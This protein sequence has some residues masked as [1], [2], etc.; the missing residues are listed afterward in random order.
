M[1]PGCQWTVA[2]RVL[3][4]LGGE[5]HHAGQRRRLEEDSGDATPH[6]ARL[7][8]ITAPEDHLP[9]PSFGHATPRLQAACTAGKS[10]RFEF[11][12]TGR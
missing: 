8:T 10:A 2:L 6:H 1:E 4:E 11:G 9:Y 12:E 5:E 7:R 3:E